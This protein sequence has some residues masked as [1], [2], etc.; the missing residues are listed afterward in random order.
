MTADTAALPSTE[1]AASTETDWEA[2]ADGLATALRLALV[3]NPNLPAE[4]WKQGQT[5]IARYVT[6]GGGSLT[7]D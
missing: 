1:T 6:A 5:A 4:A 7:E 3:R 2:I